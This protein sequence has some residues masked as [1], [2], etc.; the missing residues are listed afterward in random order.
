VEGQAGARTDGVGEWFRWHGE[1]QGHKQTD[2]QAKILGQFLPNLL[3]D[4]PLLFLIY[5]LTF[6]QIGS[7]F[8]EL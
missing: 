1:R 2:G 6:V 3:C 8:G 5:I 4:T 7:G